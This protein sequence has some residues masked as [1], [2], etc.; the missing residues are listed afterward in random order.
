MLDVNCFWSAQEAIQKWKA[1]EQYDPYWLEEPV[2]PPEDY[3]SLAKVSG[4]LKTPVAVG[5]N[6]SNLYGFRELVNHNAAD[7]LQPSITKVG[8][9]LEC[10]KICELAQEAHLTVAPHSF[11]FGP[12]LAATLHL[13]A[14]L[15][16]CPFVELRT[17]DLA[18][19][20]LKN[21]LEAVDG[22]VEVP[23]GPGLGVE[24]NDDTLTDFI[25]R[26]EPEVPSY[27]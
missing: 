2:W 20:L 27:I 14:T 23:T 19:P 1:Y 8:G 5:E 10:K 25:Y 22:F 15:P 7:I 17:E 21:P 16:N 3:Y 26:A 18:S 11:Y 6:E 13:I 4:I 24:L 9:L 12:G